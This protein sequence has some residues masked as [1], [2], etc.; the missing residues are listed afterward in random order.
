M[1]R[2]LLLASIGC[3]F[4]V[5]GVQF[6]SSQETRTRNGVD[7]KPFVKPASGSGGFI[8][9][10]PVRYKN[11]TIFP[12]LSKAELNSD[13]FITLDEGLRAHTVE[14]LEMGARQSR[15]RS[16]IRDRRIPA[17]QTD[18]SQRAVPQSSRQTRQNDREV[19]A[20]LTLVL[21]DA[22]N[23][24][25]NSNQVNRLL[26]VNRSD[27]PLY[28]MPGE[29]I[30]GGSQDRAIGEEL[31]IAP[32]GKPVPIDVFCVEHGRWGIRDAGQATRV[33]ASLDPA[34]TPA[35][36]NSRLAEAGKQKF[37]LSAGSLSKET[38]EAVQSGKG[39]QAVWDSV[40]KANQRVGT[41]FASVP[42]RSITR[43]PR[44]SKN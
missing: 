31:T 3:L 37:V 4:V 12:V 7:A 40:G 39:Q 21:V 28:L 43:I 19:I 2:P 26:V 13:R 11:L 33:L 44:S 27:R 29:V 25:T 1:R 20:P 36:S 30:V 5:A 15:S 17:A 38:R 34:A 22:E 41:S 8:V 14:V 9:G 16:A 23:E 42:S 18:T 32:T 35:E 10:T 6:G 24:S